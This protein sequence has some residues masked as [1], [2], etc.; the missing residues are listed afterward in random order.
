M[1]PDDK[2][3]RKY[4]STV[5]EQTINGRKSS[6]SAGSGCRYLPFLQSTKEFIQAHASL[7]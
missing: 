5:F 1:T 3:S 7:P 2:K 4:F 6:L